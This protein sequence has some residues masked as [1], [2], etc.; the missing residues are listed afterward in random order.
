MPSA[1]AIKAL[2]VRK[3]EIWLNRAALFGQMKLAIPKPM[4]AKP[5][6]VVFQWRMRRWKIIVVSPITLLTS[7]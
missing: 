2:A 4:M 1:A 7:P 3:V 6:I 5:P